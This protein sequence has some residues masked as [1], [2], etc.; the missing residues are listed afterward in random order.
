MEDQEYERQ[1][2]LEA[3]LKRQRR[4]DALAEKLGQFLNSEERSEVVAA[5]EAYDS[6]SGFRPTPLID[7][8]APLTASG[9]KKL[10]EIRQ[11]AAQLAF[12]MGSAPWNIQARL[13]HD[14][15]PQIATVEQLLGL[16][17]HVSEMLESTPRSTSGMPR[18]GDFRVECDRNLRN[19][20]KA[21]FKSAKKRCP[22]N[23][24]NF[25][26]FFDAVISDAMRGYGGIVP[27]T[28]DAVRKSLER[29]KPDKTRRVRP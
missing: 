29:R 28:A 13:L 2:A 7:A 21:I 3:A 25:E 14:W 10:V 20:L 18:T 17:C 26:K 5:I 11:K 4:L 12:V 27:A 24:M 6:A 22:S 8:S 23:R 1:F 9:A 16:A 19:S 15:S